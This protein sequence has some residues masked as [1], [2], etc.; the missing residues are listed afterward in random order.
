MGRMTGRVVIKLITEPMILI[1]GTC[2]AGH[3]P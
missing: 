2:F 1:H 3:S